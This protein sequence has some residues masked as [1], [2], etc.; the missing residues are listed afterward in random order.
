MVA[1][2]RQTELHVVPIHHVGMK[3]IMRQTPTGKMLEPYPVGNNNVKIRL[4]KRVL[5]DDLLIREYESPSTVYSYH[6]S[7]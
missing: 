3:G 2:A 5:F 1:N 7:G 6:I 4:G